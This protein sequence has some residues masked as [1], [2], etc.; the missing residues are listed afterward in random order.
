MKQSMVWKTRR[1]LRLGLFPAL[2][3]LA[4]RLEVLYGAR[5]G[6]VSEGP[7]ESL[8]LGMNVGD[9]KKRVQRNREL[10]LGAAGFDPRT[11]AR[12]E[13]IHGGAVEIARRGTRHRGVAGLVTGDDDLPLA[14]STADCYAVIIYA[15]PE[16]AIAALHVG[17]MGAAEGIIER[18]TILLQ[19]A[20]HIDASKSIALI[21]PGICPE[22]YKVGEEVAAQ[23]PGR[24]AKPRDGGFSLDLPSFCR[25]E[26]KRSGI[27]GER[28]FESG[29]CTAC[30]PR[31]FFSYR[32]DGGITGRHWMLA[33]NRPW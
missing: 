19:D 30:N 17:R 8:N 16:R 3:A 13:Q 23:F 9:S 6:G 26:L 31:L 20:F 15:P 5:T 33:R 32:R 25:D 29:L 28:I 11:L 12:G 14:V 22:C 7:Y 2:E 4:P 1:G 10:L 24:Y 18:S 27:P 21:G